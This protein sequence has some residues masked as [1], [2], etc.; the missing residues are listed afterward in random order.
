VVTLGGPVGGRNPRAKRPRHPKQRGCRVRAL[1]R[2]LGC[3]SGRIGGRGGLHSRLRLAGG[4]TRDRLARAVSPDEPRSR[5]RC[6]WGHLGCLLDQRRRG[7][8]RPR[9]SRGLPGRP[10]R[11][12]GAP[13]R[14]SSRRDVDVSNRDLPGAR[15]M[16]QVKAYFAVEGVRLP[17]HCRHRSR[18]KQNHYKTSRG[19]HPSEISVDSLRARR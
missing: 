7:A 12:P 3:L 5:H 10:A 6:P 18:E 9:S 4:T 11:W 19:A 15:Q 2:S 16:E 17:K 8:L 13:I 1:D 14:Q